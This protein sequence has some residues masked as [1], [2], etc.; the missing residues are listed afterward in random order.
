MPQRVPVL[1]VVLAAALPLLLMAGVLMARDARTGEARIARDRVSQAR[2][3]ALM[4]DT[5]VTGNLQAVEALAA[6]F[7]LP[8]GADRSAV[9]D[10]LRRVVEA[11]PNWDRMSIVGP[12]GQNLYVSEENLRAVSIGDRSYFQQL[13]SSERPL[14]S[15]AMIGRLTGRPIIVFAAPVDLPGGERGALIVPVATEVL[16]RDLAAVFGSG[17]VRI[18]LVDQEGQ[19]FAHPNEERARVLERASGTQHAA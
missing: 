14:V 6:A 9:E 1:L 3:V 16:S 17:T 10:R 7:D 18:V 19:L 11:S 8:S 5:Y 2:G 4:V 15:A 13:M 12:D